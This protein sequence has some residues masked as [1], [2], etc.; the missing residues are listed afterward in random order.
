[1][2]EKGRRVLSRR[3][4]DLPLAVRAGDFQKLSPAA[5]ES[6]RLE[7]RADDAYALASPSPQPPGRDYWELFRKPL[8]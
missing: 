6:F 5:R 8:G 4:S 2:S 7:A 1:M 3:A